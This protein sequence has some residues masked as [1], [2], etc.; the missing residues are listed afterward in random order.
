MDG[1]AAAGEASQKTCRFAQKLIAA[2]GN[3]GTGRI[4]CNGGV[5]LS[6]SVFLFLLTAMPY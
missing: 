6:L 1:K 3:K 4:A 5:G 2:F